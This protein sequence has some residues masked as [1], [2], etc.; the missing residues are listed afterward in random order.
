MEIPRWSTVVFDLDG[1]L[2]DS[3]AL[4]VDCYQHT[5]RTVLGRPWP[6]ADE[7]RSWMGIP[8]WTIFQQVDPD[9]ADTMLDVYTTWNLAHTADYVQE[10]A[11]VSAMLDAL[12]RAGVAISVATS[13][14]RPA[15]ELGM[16]CAGLTES[17]PLLVTGDDVTVHK[18]APDPLLSAVAQL[19]G[20]PRASAYVG[21]AVVDIQAARNADMSSIAVSWGAGQADALAAEC[22]DHEVA[23]VQELTALILSG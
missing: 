17:I 13:K 18:P 6:D 19:G 1:T 12:R 11:G 9:R 7:V 5:F 2:L 14:R 23:T 20:A 16:R 22:P 4:T 15:A 10:Y 3:V 21:D 8:L